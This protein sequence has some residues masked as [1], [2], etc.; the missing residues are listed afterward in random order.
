[1]VGRLFGRRKKRPSGSATDSLGDTVRE[2]RAGDVFTIT[3]LSP[4]YEDSYLIVEKMNRYESYAGESYE[5]LGVEGDKRLWVQWSDE[6][7]LFVTAM[8]DDE[9]RGLKQLGVTEDQLARMDDEQ[10]IDNYVTHDGA[11]YFY[12][13][14]GEAGYF[15]D[16]TGDG[17]GFY[18][19][20]FAGEDKV[21]SV[22]KWEGMPFRVYVSDVVSPDS[23]S[24]YKR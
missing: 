21:L 17:E 2:A 24:V 8:A 19:W 18:L 1:M 11:Q 14:S 10:S 7:G 3:G 4:E 5:L 6:G 13:N 12:K 9:P 22:V 20:E 15:Q 16:N 23:I